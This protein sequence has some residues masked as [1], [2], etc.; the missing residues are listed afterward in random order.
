M[1]NLSTRCGAYDHGDCDGW[2]AAAL[3]G[4]PETKCSC[5]CHD[6]NPSCWR[7]SG[8]GSYP[9]DLP[10]FVVCE[11]VLAKRKQARS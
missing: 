5:E 6:A 4:D 10:E 8:T 7:C 2:V 3:R 1:A 9:D 11:C